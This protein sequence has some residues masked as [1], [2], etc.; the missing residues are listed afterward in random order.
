VVEDDALVVQAMTQLF[1]DLNLPLLYAT[2]AT[3]ALA[4]APQACMVACDVRLPGGMSGLDLALQLQH[5]AIPT[6][7]MTGETS[8]DIRAF[9]QQHGLQLLIK[10]VAPQVF[11]NG[12]NE[13]AMR[14]AHVASA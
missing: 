10:P 2:N 7:L 14:S 12:L 3:Q 4:L 13:L 6:L 5:M 11:L 1:S 8:A 9:A